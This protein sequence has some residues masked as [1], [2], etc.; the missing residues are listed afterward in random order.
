[1]ASNL[2][3]RSRAH[4]RCC[5][6]A[7]ARKPAHA[8][9]PPKLIGPHVRF[10]LRDEMKPRWEVLVRNPWE[11]SLLIQQG[12]PPQIS[13]PPSTHTKHTA[14]PDSAVDYS[15]SRCAPSNTW[16]RSSGAPMEART[17]ALTRSVDPVKWPQHDILG[18]PSILEY[19]RTLTTN[20]AFNPEL[21]ALNPCS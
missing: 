17:K 12:A 2:I 20:K 9:C 19:D 10:Q 8:A 11:A 21:R 5:S 15:C 3:T 1:M 4:Q 13:L 7:P 6:C 14:R 18:E 16:S